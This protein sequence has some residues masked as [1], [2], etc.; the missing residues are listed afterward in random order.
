M[1]VLLAL[2]SL[3]HAQQQSDWLNYSLKSLNSAD[4]V[5]LQQYKDKPT[6]MIFF[7]PKCRWCFKQIR[8]LSQLQS[9]CHQRFNTLAM[10]IN[11]SQKALRQFYSRTGVELPAFEVSKRMA[12][13]IG[14]IPATPITILIDEEGQA[15][16]A[17]RGYKP[18]AKLQPLLQ[19]FAPDTFSQCQ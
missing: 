16:G 5:S 6:L 10:G 19:Q 8:E 4:K 1:V 15:F 9:N 14:T 3:S 7:E 13:D 17:V 2:N 11:G 18:I 12:A